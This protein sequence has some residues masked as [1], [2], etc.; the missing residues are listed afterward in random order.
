MAVSAT[1]AM[2]WMPA[3]KAKYRVACASRSGAFTHRPTDQPYSSAEISHISPRQ[4]VGLTCA[5]M[6]TC[7][8]MLTSA[9]GIQNEAPPIAA[10]YC[11]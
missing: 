8:T 6:K 1:E 2:S 10:A 3:Y 7:A 9:Y 5:I 4:D 11:R